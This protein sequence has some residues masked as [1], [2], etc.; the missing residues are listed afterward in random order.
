MKYELLCVHLHA[1]FSDASAAAAAAARRRLG[2]AGHA[3]VA[4][5]APAALAE[6]CSLTRTPVNACEIRSADRLPC[7][8]IQTLSMH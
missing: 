1:G 6:A 3:R 8:H 4:L 5:E 7:I 2:G